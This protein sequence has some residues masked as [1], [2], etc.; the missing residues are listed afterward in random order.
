MKLPPPPRPAGDA[1]IRPVVGHDTGKASIWLFSGI[2]LLGAVLLFTTLDGQRRGRLAPTTQPRLS[3]GVAMPAA[4]PPLQIPQEI[5]LAPPPPPPPSLM[6]EPAQNIVATPPQTLPVAVAPP[7]Q[8]TYSSQSAAAYSTPPPTS[9]AIAERT[10]SRSQVLVFDATPGVRAAPVTNAAPGD[11]AASSQGAAAS[12]ADAPLRATSSAR[13]PLTIPQGTLIPA[14]LETALDSTRPGAVRAM[15][16]RDV[17]GFDGR[18]I[19]IPRGTRLYGEYE[20]DLKPGQK[21]A[22]VQWTRLVRPDGVAIA[23]NSPAADAQGRT[24]IPGRVNTHFLQRFGSSLLQST[25]NLG[26]TLVGRNNGNSPVVVAL[27]GATEGAIRAAS[28]GGEQQVQPTLRVEA[29]VSVTVFVAQDLQFPP[30]RP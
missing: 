10:A 16:S 27:P 18:Q 20:A 24:G 11:V 13:G 25:L 26:V 19:L 6:Y 3:D 21:R 12:T 1:D 4:L 2:V 28:G 14:V 30:V 5:E 7:V 22:F 8:T 15:V 17:T 23:I 9:V 29:G